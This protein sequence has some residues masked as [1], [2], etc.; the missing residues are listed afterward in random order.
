MPISDVGSY[1][2]TMDEFSAHRDDVNT[3]LGG[4]PATDLKLQGGYTR[5]M[6][7]ADRDAIDAA[8][9]GLVGLGIRGRSRPRIGTRSSRG[10]SAGSLR[11]GAF[12]G[13]CCP[14]PAK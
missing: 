13:R 14:T 5:A 1:A 2:P 3:A 9:T 11:F 12:C 8:M 4:A 6:F 10:W 7:I